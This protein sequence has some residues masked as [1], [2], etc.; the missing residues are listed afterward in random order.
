MP[1]EQSRPA[2]LFRPT[3]KIPSVRYFRCAL[4]GIRYFTVF[5]IPTS[6]SVFENTAVSVRYRYY[7]PT[8]SPVIFRWDPTRRVLW[9]RFLRKTYSNR[10]DDNDLRESSS[11][12]KS[13][14]TSHIVQVLFATSQWNFTYG[15][16][17]NNLTNSSFHFFSQMYINTLCWTMHTK[18]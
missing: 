13:L 9:G 15:H 18:E 4:V 8:I 12:S 17:I 5:I 10:F 6:V 11:N 2:P 7:R 16:I 1:L 14:H 3:P